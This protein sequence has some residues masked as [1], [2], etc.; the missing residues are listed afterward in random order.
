MAEKY[1]LTNIDGRKISVKNHIFTWS[2]LISFLRILISVPIIWLHIQ[3]D[4]EVN[5]LI[6]GVI[7]IGVFSDYLDGVV[8]RWRDE[9]SE[10]GKVLDPVADK[11]LAGILFAYTVWLGL[12]P[13]WFLVVAVIR[14]L[15][16]VAG[17]IH[18]KRTR[19]KVAM[20]VFSGKVS[21]NVLAVYWVSVFFFPEW[22][23]AHQV[24]MVCSLI[25]MAYSFY[26]YVQRF[27]QIRKGAEFN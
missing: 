20:A 23:V 24:F 13:L 1:K 18:I 16:I 7:V 21:V 15:L 22:V 27:N 9:V 19:G 2:N 5:L 3:N 26:Y 10:L 12:I 14:D 4:Y 11:S 6:T 17:S 8:A 25:V